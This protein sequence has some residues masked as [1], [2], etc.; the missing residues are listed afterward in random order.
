MSILD[1]KFYKIL[2]NITSVVILQFLWMVACLPII[3]IIPATVALFSCIRGRLF[4]KSDQLIQKFFKE[5]KIEFVRSNVV[6]I[7]LLIVL[8]SLSQY[9]YAFPAFS[10]DTWVIITVAVYMISGIY[11]LFLMHLLTFHVHMNYST[12]DL[13]KNS[14]LAV[15]YQPLKSLAILIGILLIFYLSLLI[16]ILF[17]LCSVSLIGFLCVYLI[18]SKF[19]GK[20]LNQGVNSSE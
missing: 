5:L 17:F 4:N 19:H 20:R 10:K 8:V 3:T 18:L 7:P 16:P 1:S 6:G 14:F 15:F 2:D 12:E 11:V 13:M 9:F